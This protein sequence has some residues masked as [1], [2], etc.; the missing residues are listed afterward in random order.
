MVPKDPESPFSLLC[1]DSREPS[2]VCWSL[3]HCRR[4]LTGPPILLMGFLLPACFTCLAWPAEWK[5]AVTSTCIGSS[6]ECWPRSDSQGTKTSLR[7]EPADRPENQP[8]G[9]VGTKRHKISL[10]MADMAELKKKTSTLK[11]DPFAENV[12]ISHSYKETHRVP[13]PTLSPVSLD[14][15][16]LLAC[17]LILSPHMDSQ[18]YVSSNLAVSGKEGPTCLL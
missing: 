4:R 18:P 3:H 15:P 8:L 13:G 2:N 10:C 17:T 16:C 7:E 12:L 11:P 9:L 14:T 5:V 1:T 6:L